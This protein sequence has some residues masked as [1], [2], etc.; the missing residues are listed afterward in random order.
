MRFAPRLSHALVARGD[1]DRDRYAKYRT[2]NFTHVVG[3]AM[4]TR[5]VAE[6]SPTHDAE[7]PDAE[8]ITVVDYYYDLELDA[9]GRIL[10]GEWYLNKHPDFL[11]TP[12][13]TTRATTPGDPLAT[14]GWSPPDPVPETWRAAAARASSA[15]LPLAK[16]VEQLIHI[17][18]NS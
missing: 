16:I 9:A 17:A 12:A 13:R 2:S 14:G 18:N 7:P 11:W 3:V 8:A 6:V 10:G 1:F 15:G 5:Y 4:R